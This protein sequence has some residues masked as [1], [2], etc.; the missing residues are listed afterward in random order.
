[1]TS[2]MFAGVR[3]DLPLSK[4]FGNSLDDFFCGGGSSNSKSSVIISFTSP[5]YTI[6]LPVGGLPAGQFSSDLTTLVT[7][8]GTRGNINSQKKEVPTDSPRLSLPTGPERMHRWQ[9]PS[10]GKHEVTIRQRKAVIWTHMALQ[11]REALTQQPPIFSPFL[12]L[13]SRGIIS[14]CIPQ[15][16]I[17]WFKELLI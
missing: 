8:A 6:S 17:P 9:N 7:S 2:W 15:I 12:H 10:S 11:T 14:V 13:I 1:M 4:G 3:S 16:T 5:S